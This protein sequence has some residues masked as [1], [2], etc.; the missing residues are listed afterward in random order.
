MKLA[1]RAYAVTLLLLLLA[2]AAAAQT[3][4]T[5]GTAPT[6]DKNAR[7]AKDPRN[8]APTVG[9]GGPIGGPTGLFTVY[10]QETLRKGEWTLS[11]AWSNYDR[12]PGN[13]DFTDVPL[14][15]QYGLTNRIELFFTTTGYRGL[16]I[17]NPAALSGFY[18]PNTGLVINGVL[19]SAPAIIL[20]PQGPG[21]SLF[22]NAAVFR[23]TG[24]APFVSSPFIGGSLGNF[25]LGFGTSGPIFGFPVNTFALIGSP[26]AGSN[27][28]VAANFPGLGSVF[29]G[30]LPGIVLSTVTLT[31]ANGAPAGEGPLAFTLAPS[32]LPDAPFMDRTWSTS[33]FNDFTGGVKWRFNSPNSPVGY[34]IIAYYRWWADHANSDSGFNMLQ[35]GAGPGGNRG[36]I[37]VVGFFGARLAKW[38]NL[39][40]NVG[41]NW[42]SS[43]KADF[44]NGTFTILDRP[45]E[46]LL[47]AGIDF[48]IS[49]WVQPI[50]EFRSLRYMGGHT[51]NALE[52]N[53][54]DIIA[55]VR[56]FP[57]RWWGIGL[58]YRYHV[59]EEDAGFFK[60]K[61]FPS[62]LIINCSNR[63]VLDG[64][65]QCTP[66]TINQSFTGLPP[67]FLPSEDPHG[68][69]VQLFA[70]RRHKRATEVINLPANV[71][72][73]TLSSNAL[74]LGCPPGQIP[75]EGQTCDQSTSINVT[76]TAVDPE[77][78][79]L[80]Y[81]YTVSGG[82]IVGTG[83][84]VSWDLSGVAPGSYTITAGV[85]DGCGICGKTM[86]QTATVANCNCKVACNCPSLTV[87][88]PAGITP[89][90]G[91][92][93]FVA[94]VSGGS[95]DQVVTYNWTVSAGTISS[96][97]GTPSITVTAP[98]DGSVSN[99]TATVDL[100]GLDPSCNCP[101]EA[102]ETAGVAPL[103]QANE[104]DTFGPLSNDDVKARVQNFYVQL[105][106]NPNS[107]G[108]ILNYGTPKQIAS[109]RTQITKAI[110]FLKLDPSRVTFVDGPPHGA[111][112][113]THFYLVPPGATPP[114]P[115]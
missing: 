83:P 66:T 84:T 69:I 62:T 33:S 80:T 107:Q 20:A 42:N 11:A 113:E 77:N 56:L 28:T 65:S 18:L 71:T 6:Y 88:G 27:S 81:Q 100:G 45:D 25:G 30:I 1:Y 90:G 57:A 98:S 85:D 89:P 52:N 22:P 16:K 63:F 37:G 95:Q 31:N 76:T 67:G 40:A 15:A 93:T 75:V 97:Q 86:T 23:P 101:H 79:V 104:V 72:A 53:P 94:N 39:S 3:P 82:R 58:A 70:G 106:N 46:L 41:Y 108:Y 109:R 51:P 5:S 17:N 60:D 14:S 59:N 34:G 92:M 61:T 47:S 96:G 9:T 24:T 7:S 87:T 114:T 111:D 73:L 55:G 99:I 12:D 29:G 35:R 32:Y 19:Q 115:Q 4:R 54:M 10:D 26:I 105:A 38:A 50:A 68:F 102:N 78:D 74:T 44:P 103:P 8:T 2:F 110:T 49:K 21:V 43:T 36:D 91:S 64:E 48:P 112:V 13:A